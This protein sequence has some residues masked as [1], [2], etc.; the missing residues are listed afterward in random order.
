MVNVFKT[1]ISIPVFASAIF[2]GII[3]VPI[4]QG[5][6]SAM[7][8]MSFTGLD[9]IMWFMAFIIWLFIVIGIPGYYYYMGV[10]EKNEKSSFSNILSAGVIFIFGLALIYKGFYMVQAVMAAV[11]ATGSNVFY[12]IAWIGTMGFILAW[13]I[14]LPVALYIEAQSSTQSGGEN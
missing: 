13:L 2:V 8:A 3:S 4:L 1:L 11:E 14:G 6:E 7:N 9:D 5:L 12:T 10:I